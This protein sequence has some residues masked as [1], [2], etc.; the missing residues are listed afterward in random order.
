MAVKKL[1]TEGYIADIA[2][3]LRTV[4]GDETAKYNTR[5]MAATLATI[6]RGAKDVWIGS[7]MA[8]N[9]LGTYDVEIVYII[10][11]NRSIMRVYAGTVI[12]YDNPITW[13]YDLPTTVY[14]GGR[15]EWTITPVKPLETAG[16]AFEYI[17]SWSNFIR[18]SVMS[19]INGNRSKLCLRVEGGVTY[20]IIT[21]GSTI[22]LSNDVKSL[23]VARDISN[24]VTVY[25]NDT[26]DI[27]G[28]AT[29]SGADENA[30]V[31]GGQGS[32]YHSSAS[33]F[34]LDEFKFR[35]IV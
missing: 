27:L 5:E 10:Y 6:H 14:Q 8:Y 34:T 23:K 12:L 32:D 29:L 35:Y 2:D 16:T 20:F 26:G 9:Q 25:D 1:Y 31:I 17:I 3:A 19:C 4:V 15:D 30:I 13:D 22:T 33:A 11:E 21:N 7:Q 18:G 24:V 28:N